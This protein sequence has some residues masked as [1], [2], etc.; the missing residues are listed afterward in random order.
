[1]VAS[2]DDI[3]STTENVGF[4]PLTGDPCVMRMTDGYAGLTLQY[5]NGVLG[6]STSSQEHDRSYKAFSYPAALEYRAMGQ[7]ASNERAMIISNENS[8]IID[9]RKDNGQ[10]YLNFR[11][12]G[13]GASCNLRD[14]LSPGDLINVFVTDPDDGTYDPTKSVG[15]F[16]ISSID[17]NRV[18]LLKHSGSGSVSHADGVSLRIIRSGRTNQLAVP[19]AGIST[20]SP[21]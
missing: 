10:H 4:N 13:A 6:G 9:K 14:L 7:K 2:Q 16:H 3:A 21:D 11:F 5:A 19:R 12:V 20:Y 15:V 1:V 8:V 18:F 17:G